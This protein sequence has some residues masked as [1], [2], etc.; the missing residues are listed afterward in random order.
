MAAAGSSSD[1]GPKGSAT[2]GHVPTVSVI[3]PCFNGGHFLDGLMVSFD[4]QTFRDFE[5][6]IVDDG[7]T[8]PE[9]RRKLAALETRVRIVRQENGGPSVARNRGVR[10]ARGDIL[11]MLDCDDTIE[12]SFLAEAVAALQG[13]PPGTGM[14]FADLRLGGA[15]GGFVSRYFNRF[16]LLFTNTMANGLVMRRSVFDAAG[17]YDETM[18]EG[19]ED[20]DF[21]L[22]LAGAG[23]RGLRIPRPLYVYYIGSDDTHPSRSAGVDKRM[24]YGKLWRAIRERHR[25]SF[26]PLAMLRLWRQSR[27]GSGRI[28][29]WKGI[30]A[31]LAANIL[32][33]AVFN[34]L[35]KRL[36]RGPRADAPGEPYGDA[37]GGARV[38]P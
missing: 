11:F 25:E 19:Y 20:W 37:T 14:V 2:A 31:W 32:P 7:S 34:Q 33:E 16:D 6:V 36:H 26:R 38:A 4:A 10:E 1:Q 22:R 9:T 5:V 13:A 30:A 8:E 12:P 21:S 27:D 17:G 24:L 28:P 29:L 3:V 18:R 15:E 23:F 35:I